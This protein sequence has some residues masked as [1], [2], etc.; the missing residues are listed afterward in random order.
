MDNYLNDNLSVFKFA[1]HVKVLL[2]SWLFWINLSELQTKYTSEEIIVNNGNSCIPIKCTNFT[3]QLTGHCYCPETNGEFKNFLCQFHAD[4]ENKD[5]QDYLCSC[6]H[7]P[8]NR[9][10]TKCKC[11]SQEDSLTVKCDV[12]SNKS[13]IK[14]GVLMYYT[15]KVNE[16]PSIY[17]SGPYYAS[18]MFVARDDINKNS[19]LL[20]NH[21]FNLVWG[22]T[23]CN[24]KKTVRLAMKMIEEQQ[25]DAL[26]GVGCGGCLEI[27]AISGIYNVPM[28]SHVRVMIFNI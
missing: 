18:A 14:V 19:F 6:N 8:T 4:E 11:V 17:Y 23:E 15:G 27:A 20:P 2:L 1:D 28:I 16:F 10:A 12:I 24:K 7:L 13:V 9:T 25:V 26:I 21:R 3:K 5:Y 22:N